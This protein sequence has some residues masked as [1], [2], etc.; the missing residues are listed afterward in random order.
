METS[1]LAYAAS[2]AVIPWNPSFWFIQV[3]IMIV[4][5]LLC[6]FWLGNSVGRSFLIGYL[7][8]MPITLVLGYFSFGLF[9]GYLTK[10][11]AL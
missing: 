9:L 5:I 10:T 1:S 7:A 8:Q 3:P 2:V 6:I 4:V 11:R